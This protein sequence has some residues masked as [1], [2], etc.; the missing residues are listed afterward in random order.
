MS[1][2]APKI[3]MQSWQ[4]MSA[5]LRARLPKDV[6]S[7]FAN[8]SGM[9]YFGYVDKM[10]DDYKVVRGFTVSASHQDNHYTVGTIDGYNIRLVH[11]TDTIWQDNRPTTHNWLIMAIDLQTQEPIPHFLIGANNRDLR[12]FSALF[13]SFPN[14]H[15]MSSCDLGK[16]ADKE[17]VS[18]FS[19]YARPAKAADVLS[20]F[21]I[22]ATRTLAAH[23][24]P[25]SVEQ[26]DNVLY[27]YSVDD[28]VTAMLLETMLKNGLWLANHLDNQVVKLEND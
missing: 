3:L 15:P 9:V 26:H 25:L 20:L 23:F 2:T 18:R 11:R 17:F 6:I 22:D 21:T 28:K 12:P 13:S 19:I 1:Q 24:W 5:S 27:I 7:K 8:K 10:S 4:K 16:N 14:M